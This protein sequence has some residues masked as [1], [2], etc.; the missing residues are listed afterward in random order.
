MT[1]VNKKSNLNPN[2]RALTF[3]GFV[4]LTCCD[5]SLTRDGDYFQSIDK[6]YRFYVYFYQSNFKNYQ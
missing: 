2:L 5:K 3:E 1:H 4:I 6:S